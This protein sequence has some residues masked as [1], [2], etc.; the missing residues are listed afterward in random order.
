MSAIHW[1]FE[2]RIITKDITFIILQTRDIRS[3]FMASPYF[4]RVYDSRLWK[5]ENGVIWEIELDDLTPFPL[6]REQRY[7]IDNML[8]VYSKFKIIKHGWFDIG[9]VIN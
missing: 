5:M 9:R 3:Q 2:Y 1:Q 7:R 4:C 6:T 8:E